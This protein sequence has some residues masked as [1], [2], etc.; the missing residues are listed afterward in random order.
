M[1]VGEAGSEQGFVQIIRCRSRDRRAVE[2]RA[3]AFGGAKALVTDR[4][5]YQADDYLLLM[6]KRNGDGELRIAVGEVG[7][8]VEGIDEPAPIWLRA[9]DIGFFFG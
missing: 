2:R 3:L 9:C 6:F 4:I 1:V 5:V 8:A 7:G